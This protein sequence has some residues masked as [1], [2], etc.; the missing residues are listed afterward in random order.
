MKINNAKSGKKANGDSGETYD[1][2][3]EIRCR[4][5]TTK[6]NS[7]APHCIGFQLLHKYTRTYARAPTQTT[8]T[9]GRTLSYNRNFGEPKLSSAGLS[10]SFSNDFRL[11]CQYVGFPIQFEKC[12]SILKV[13]FPIPGFGHSVVLV[14]SLFG[15]SC[16]LL[17]GY[18]RAVFVIPDCIYLSFL[19]RN[20]LSSSF[21]SSAILCVASLYSYSVR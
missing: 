14:T 13:M 3:R 7:V 19:L 9:Y 12:L 16:N 8:V 5:E 1:R 4:K 18:Q 20:F 10:S 2:R 21:R 6:A 11:V 15:F 17:Q